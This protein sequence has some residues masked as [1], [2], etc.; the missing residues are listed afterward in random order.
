VHRIAWNVKM[1]TASGNEEE[2]KRKLAVR[3][4]N[5]QRS[6]RKRRDIHM[7]ELELNA[8]QIDRMQTLLAESRRE[9]ESLRNY[10]NKL[11]I[12][13]N[14]LLAEYNKTPM[15][16]IQPGLSSRKQGESL[17]DY[18]NKLQLEV[19]TLL[20]DNGSAPMFNIQ[21]V[22]AVS[23]QQISPAVSELRSLSNHSVRPLQSNNDINDGNKSDMKNSTLSD[24]GVTIIKST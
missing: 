6:F 11:Q 8:S 5:A 19:N 15:F 7:Q 3:N 20:V 18:I 4:R 21:P 12:E 13:V 22:S 17:R 1:S 14:A 9:C 16:D 23:V 24:S 2:R 10:I